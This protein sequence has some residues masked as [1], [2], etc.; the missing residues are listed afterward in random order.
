MQRLWQR[1]APRRGAGVVCGGVQLS[2]RDVKGYVS[3]VVLYTAVYVT[4]KDE[5]SEQTL[6]AVYPLAATRVYRRF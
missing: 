6:R 1:E 3:G 2:Y 4:G 5:I